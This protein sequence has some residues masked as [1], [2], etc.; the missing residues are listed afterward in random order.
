M[1]PC[2]RKSL[3]PGVGCWLEWGLLVGVRGDFVV[4]D[5]F[6]PLVS[7]TCWERWGWRCR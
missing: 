7:P 4:V 2:F 3:D 6:L 1:V 5:P